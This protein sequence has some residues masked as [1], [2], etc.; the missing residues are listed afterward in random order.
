MKRNKVC[1]LVL[2]VLSAILLLTAC[3][4]DQ[5]KNG[6]DSQVTYY[7]VTFDSAGG[8]PVSAKKAV[9]GEKISE[10]AVPQ[11][12]GYLFDGWM[13]GPNNQWLF[14]VDTVISDVTL[15]A[16][17]ISAE[18][19]FG[20]RKLEGSDT[21]AITQL[22]KKDFAE[23]RV[24]SVLGGWT[25]TAIDAEVFA[26]IGKADEEDEDNVIREIILPKTV[27]A[28]GERAF[29]DTVNVKIT[30]EEG[31]VITSLGEQAFFNCNQLTAITLGEGLQTVPFEAFSGCV[32]LK[33]IRLPKSVTKVEENAFT[34]CTALVS[35]M[36]YA[37]LLQ[38]DNMAFDDCTALKAVY[39][40]GTAEQVDACREQRV[41]S[42]NTPLLGA[43]W[44]LYSETKPTEIG[45]YSYWYLTE[46]GSIKA[47]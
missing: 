24:P 23:V 30:F 3:Q 44:L 5:D 10:P 21:A 13:E 46:N 27:N 25:V 45:A 35:V 7:T 17:W 20:Y 11:K 6:D 15:T 29:A 40:F 34:D 19:V 9:S 41:N 38:V 37:E 14:D 47:W 39:C 26:G 42:T 32:A 8:T 43:K 16:H 31:S 4:E 28:I 33:A 36:L 22:K 2:L 12:E 18:S 1:F